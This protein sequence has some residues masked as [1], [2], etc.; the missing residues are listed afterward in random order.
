MSVRR[1][2]TPATVAGRAAID[3]STVSPNEGLWIA[4]AVAHIAGSEALSQPRCLLI[5][6]TD[7]D[8]HE[9]GTW[10]LDGTLRTVNRA[11]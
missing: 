10:D 4:V 3:Q 9:W 7:L 2:W 1:R 11:T 8:R 5:A 6:L